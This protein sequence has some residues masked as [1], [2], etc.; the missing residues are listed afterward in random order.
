MTKTN[1]IADYADLKLQDEL[2]TE[3]AT[4]D[5]NRSGSPD[6]HNAHLLFGLGDFTACVKICP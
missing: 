5:E 1:K 6:R 3:L 4:P 2:I